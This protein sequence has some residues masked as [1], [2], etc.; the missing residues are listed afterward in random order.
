MTRSNAVVVRIGALAILA[1]LRLV[2][3]AGIDIS[4]GE[5]RVRGQPAIGALT[6]SPQMTAAASGL[7]VWAAGQFS[8]ANT[9]SARSALQSM[10]TSRRPVFVGLSPVLQLRAQDD[11]IATS[12]RNRRIDAVFGINVGTARLGATAGVGLAQSVH[13]NSNR[14]VQTSSADVHLARGAFQLR[15]GYIG[16]AFDAS[17]AIPN[18]QSGFTLVRTRLSDITSDASWRYRA[19]EVGGFVA[20]RVGGA[21]DSRSW[22]GAFA[23]VALTDR[24]AVIARQETTPSDPTRHL[25]SQRIAT[26]G[27]RIRPTVTRARYDDG[28]DAAQYR[29]EF[30]LRRVHGDTHGIRVY[31]PDARVVELA[32]SFTEWT[33]VAMHRSSG[34]WWE[35][36]MPLSAGL[37]TLNIRAD[38][39][40]WTVP[41]G[42]DSVADEFNGTVG[43]LL[44]R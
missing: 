25:A 7:R 37:H 1:P 12:V 21:T 26:I 24:V 4:T 40:V 9:G 44:V 8:L 2:A 29:R 20:R 36:A 31:A 33:P 27:F 19:V 13:G 17:A 43:V 18:S 35:L 38:G 34:G 28:S 42:L 22:G 32:G 23:S 39:G 6:L 3:Q 15:V 30:A 41:P 5:L 14:S 11:P 16:N 10:L